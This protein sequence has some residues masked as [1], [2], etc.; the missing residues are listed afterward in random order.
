MEFYPII[1]QVHWEDA[2]KHDLNHGY[3]LWKVDIARD[4]SSFEVYYDLIKEEDWLAI[5]KYRHEEDQQ[6]RIIS[7]LFPKLLIGAYLNESPCKISFFTNEFGKPLLQNDPSFFFNIAHNRSYFMLI[8]GPKPCGVDVE[9]QKQIPLERYFLEDIFHPDELAYI[10]RGPQREDAFFKLWVLKEAYLKRLGTGIQEKLHDISIFQSSTYGHHC[11]SRHVSE[12]QQVFK[13]S[14]DQWCG[15]SLEGDKQT[16][17]RYIDFKK[18][19]DFIVG[20]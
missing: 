14:Q 20:K 4:F 19:I 9:K 5:R 10:E 12:I 6:I 2:P 17:I 1:S 3:Q 11:Q 18:E 15:L 8:C 16:T 7:T 13:L